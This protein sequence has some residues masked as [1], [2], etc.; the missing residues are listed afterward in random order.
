MAVQFNEIPSGIRTP[1]FYAELSAASVITE[2]QGRLLLMGHKLPAGTATDDQPIRVGGSEIA[3][4]GAGSQLAQMVATARAASS[5]I[6]IWAVPVAEPGAGV[7]ATGKIAVS[8]APSSSGLVT[9]YIGG[10]RVRVAIAGTDSADDVATKLQAAIA[11]TPGI[12]V[13]AVVGAAT[14][15]VDLTALHQGAIGNDIF[16][17]TGLESSDGSLADSLLTFTAMSGGAGTPALTTAFANM[18]SETFDYIAAPFSETDTLDEVETALNGQTGRWSPTRQL[19]GHY[20][21]AR[22]GAFGV[23]SAYGNAR[24]DPHVTIMGTSNSPTDPATWVASFGAIIA[25]HLANAPEL[26]RPLQTLQI[27]GVRGPKQI[28]DRWEFSESEALL[29]DGISTFYVDA[30]GNVRIQ[31]TITTYQ[32]NAFGTDDAGQLDIQVLAQQVY[33]I[34]RLRAAIEAEHGRKALAQSN[35][36]SA[37]SVATPDDIRNTLLHEYATLENVGV[38]EN[39]SAFSEALVVEINPTDKYRV[40]VYLKADHTGQLR[41]LALAYES[42]QQL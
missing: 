33:A 3:L 25:K 14:N 11:S 29:R 5:V 16:F 28:G 36:S 40:D 27:P 2:G 13:T 30:S 21:T 38:V 35:V 8:T 7:A 34:R 42:N 31:R 24:N 1:F 9:V 12:Q 10:V 20:I 4:F 18:G 19:Y 41:I 26:N 6:D 32:R 23:I 15:E 17:V 37:S 22:P 39:L